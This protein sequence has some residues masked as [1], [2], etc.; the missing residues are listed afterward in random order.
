MTIRTPLVH[1]ICSSWFHL[2]FRRSEDQKI[3]AKSIS[4]LTLRLPCFP[5][6]DT[7]AGCPVHDARASSALLDMLVGCS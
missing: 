6:S 3:G 5:G 1:E 2:M 7:R 4:I